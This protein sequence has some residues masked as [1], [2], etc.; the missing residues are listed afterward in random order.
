MATT[1]KPQAAASAKPGRATLADDDEYVNALY[2]GKSGTGKTLA[3]AHMAKLGP[4]V[5]IN[6]ENGLK[7]RAAKQHGIDPSN[8]LIFPDPATD[9][10]L[11]FKA[12]EDLGWELKA[13][14]DD[15]PTRYA[16][17][18]WD[19]ASEIHKVLLTTHANK[20]WEKAQRNGRDRDRFFIDRPDYGVMTEQMRTLIQFYRDLP[21]HLAITALERRDQDDDG[22]I[23]YAPAVTPAL[24]ADLIGWMDIIGHTY[25]ET[26]KTG[27]E[28]R[29]DFEPAGKYQAKDR[30]EA[31]PRMLIDPFFDRIV[32]YV[33]DEIN[34]DNDPVM[35]AGRKRQ[36]DRLKKNGQ[37]A[38]AD[39]DDE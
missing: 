8:V 25:V 13:E 10:E 23:Q 4:V 18:V 7:K 34:S 11:T 16:G 17:I 36:A 1:S 30:F 35:N 2:Y 33:H 24:Q 38:A 21:C 15:D 5:F 6:A 31:L 26:F 20:M 9:E 28:Y 29:A 14:L 39:I 3:A 32:G 22:K 12:I 37:Q 27:P 19:S